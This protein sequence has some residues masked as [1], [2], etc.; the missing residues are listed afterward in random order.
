MTSG[1]DW[2]A[3]DWDA[4]TRIANKTEM[5]T[6]SSASDSTIGTTT[7]TPT[8]H[9]ASVVSNQVVSS[10][11]ST[12]RQYDPCRSWLCTHDLRLS[13]CAMCSNIPAQ[14]KLFFAKK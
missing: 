13:Q 3:I 6:R 2:D 4:I 9:G 10:S 8:S 11:E 5:L 7:T 12:P 14:L 1:I